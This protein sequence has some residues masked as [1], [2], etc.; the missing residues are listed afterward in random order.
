MSTEYDNIPINV[1]C[2]ILNDFY[3]RC[4]IDPE[5]LDDRLRTMVYY[6]GMSHIIDP[7][8]QRPLYELEGRFLR[9][10]GFRI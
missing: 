8:K 3:R 5:D 1:P 6:F 10:Q 4:D 7:E 9:K 2:E